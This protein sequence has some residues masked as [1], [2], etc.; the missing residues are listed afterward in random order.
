MVKS[1]KLKKLVLMSA[2]ID[3]DFFVNYFQRE[4]IEPTV[5][6]VEGRT[7]EVDQKFLEN[8]FQ[9]ENSLKINVFT[10]LKKKVLW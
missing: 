10:K 6:Q 4:N 1:K 9:G 7:G 3:L 5:V 8:I 2:T